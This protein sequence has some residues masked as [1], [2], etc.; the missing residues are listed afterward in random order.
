M[1]RKK[2]SVQSA[3]K[4]DIQSLQGN[5]NAGNG[6]ETKHP[7]EIVGIDDS[8]LAD[9]EKEPAQESKESEPKEQEP[10]ESEPKQEEI[11]D[12]E[13]KPEIPDTGNGEKESEKDKKQV[14]DDS[15][16]SDDSS[17]DE[18][19]SDSK[20]FTGSQ[21][22]A[23]IDRKTKPLNNQIAELQ[24]ELSE[25]QAQVEEAKN[26]G[27]LQGKVEQRKAEISKRFGFDTTILPDTEKG[28]DNFEKQM[29]EYTKGH[30]TRSIPVAKVEKEDDNLPDWIRGVS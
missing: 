22:K 3:T 30:T 15:D 7:I 10:K 13:K 11:G 6:E 4:L 26:A 8:P 14:S 20:S 25:A 2:T 29:G 23:I 21:M 1:A 16:S 12:S 24:K 5:D 19:Y 17:E 9:Q 28:L 18:D 27:M